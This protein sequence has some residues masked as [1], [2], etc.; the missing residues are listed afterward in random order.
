MK[1]VKITKIPPDGGYGWVIAIAMAINS[2]IYIPMMHC[3]GLIFKDTFSELGLSG[4]QGSLIMNL[5]AAF[6]LLTGLLNG[7]LLK[8]FGYRKIA[9]VAAV[10]YFSGVTLTSLARSFQFFIISYGIIASLGLG[11]S[12]AS[13]SLAL[14][15][16]FRKRRSKAMSVAVTITGFGSIVIPQ[17]INLLMKF[18]TPE[19][20]ILIFGGICAHFFVTA[21][22]LQPVKWHMKV[23]EEP[24]TV[25]D[26]NSKDEYNC[27]TEICD[28]TL[29]LNQN[30]EPAKN[31]RLSNIA[32][33]FDFDLLKDPIFVN[34]LIGLAFAVFS[35]LNFTI[36]IPFI[37][38]DLGLT[39]DQIATFLSTAGVAD[40]AFRFLAPY[41][42]ECLKTPPRQMYIFTLIVLIIMRSILL[43]ST[44]FYAIL[45]IAAG[46]GIAKGVRRVY[47]GLIIPSH[48]SLEK[49]PSASGM[50]MMAN[51]FCIL[52]GGFILGIVRD[53]TG[54]YYFCIV[55]MNSVTF[56]TIVLWTIEGIIFKYSKKNVPEASDSLNK[57]N[58]V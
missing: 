39:N 12:R 53:L 44:H 8:M 42:G 45:G 34:I 49:L 2:F 43:I 57:N 29:S 15:T 33:F 31:Q 50:E 41:I 56:L 55:I 18:Y 35:E 51:G 7:V 20:V 6:G 38:N 19:G 27:D 21:L 13:Y 37:L 52:S 22:L 9:L 24:L 30:E 4:A 36:L 26:R 23:E 25:Q 17:L 32:K 47:V 14:N 58:K 28:S 48:V 46:L 10:F 5:H 1:N 40:I 16:Y 11:M 3:F 54:S